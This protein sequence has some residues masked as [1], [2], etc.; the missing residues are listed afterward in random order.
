MDKQ[1]LWSSFQSTLHSMAT[2]YSHAHILKVKAPFLSVDLSFPISLRPLPR[3]ATHLRKREAGISFVCLLYQT[4]VTKSPLRTKMF[5]VPF[6]WHVAPGKK[7]NVFND[8][9]G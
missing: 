5:S 6:T 3:L 4:A 1:G 2:A 7:K 8:E 9:I